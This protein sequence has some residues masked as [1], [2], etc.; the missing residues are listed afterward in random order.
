MLEMF[1][2][3]GVERG[4]VSV[5]AEGIT[6][7]THL[8]ANAVVA[9]VHYIDGVTGANVFVMT[10]AGARALATAMGAGAPEDEAASDVLSESR[11]VGGRRGRQPDARSGRRGDQRRPR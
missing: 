5:M 2:P 3:D 6:P 8:P 9:S 4:E 1:L 10:A 7:F 11:D